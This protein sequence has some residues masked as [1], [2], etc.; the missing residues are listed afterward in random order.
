MKLFVVFMM[1]SQSINTQAQ[2]NEELKSFRNNK[3][4]PAAV[5]KNVLKALS[6]YPELI[7]AN[8]SFIFKK[9][10]KTSVMQAQ[11]VF[12]TLL[13][14]RKNRRYR[15]NISK[16]FKLIHS[17]MPIEQIPDEV[18]VGWIGH[19]LGHILDYE[20]RSNVGMISFG[21]KY[22]FHSSFVKHAEMLADSLA[23]ER[24][25]GNYIVATKRFILDH[26]ELPQ[27][28]KDKIRRLYLSPDVI[29]EQVRK[30]E[31]KKLL[32]KQK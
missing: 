31:E 7:P 25:M 26:A 2:Q 29:V 23:V 21:Y 5:E 14:R 18:M 9:N 17:Q 4:I 28:Y 16:Q 8:I 30:L 27:A 10:I 3:V 22:Y 12:M 1:V 24:G 32:E 19:E 15:V 6:F 11:P 13:S 20:S